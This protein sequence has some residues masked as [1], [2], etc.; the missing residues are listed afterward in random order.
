[1]K[2]R[3]WRDDGY[4][5]RSYAQPSTV[6]DHIGHSVYSV[7]AEGYSAVAPRPNSKDSYRL[8]PYA[9]LHLVDPQPIPKM[10]VAVDVEVDPQTEEVMMVGL[11]MT[12]MGLGEEFLFLMGIFSPH[13]TVEI[14]N[15]QWFDLLVGY[16]LYGYDMDYLVKYGL[17]GTWLETVKFRYGDRIEDLEVPFASYPIVDLYRVVQ[18]WDVENGG[19]LESFTLKDVGRFFGW[20]RY[21]TDDFL[22]AYRLGTVED[23]LL[24]DLWQTLGLALAHIPA[25][26]VKSR[27]LCFDIQRMTVLGTG[28]LIDTLLML[29]YWLFG[30]NIPKR[31]KGRE[32]YEGAYVYAQPTVRKGHIFTV[33]FTSLYPSIVEH[34]RLRPRHDFLGMFWEGVAFLKRLRVQ[35]KRQNTPLSQNLQASLKIV[36][37]SAY[38]YHGSRFAFSDIEVAKAITSTGRWKVQELVRL[39]D[40]FGE[41]VLVDT[42]GIVVDGDAVSPRD[43]QDWLNMRLHPYQVEVDKYDGVVVIAQKNYVLFR[44]DR[45][46]KVK[47]NSLRNRSDEKYI[48]DLLRN[49]I[50]HLYESGSIEYGDVVAEVA[51]RFKDLMKNPER[52]VK[53]QRVGKFMRMYR[54]E[55]VE[56]LADGERV[57]MVKYKDGWVRLNDPSELDPT[58][59]DWEYYLQKTFSAVGRLGGVFEQVANDHLKKKAMQRFSDDYGLGLAILKSRQRNR[60]QMSLV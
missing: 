34:E 2:L 16:N 39:A 3:R 12:P 47:G 14:L 4:E 45:I 60:E 32:D 11:G 33:D 19:V 52:L 41:V 25:L 22:E 6:Y 21:A 10:V 58:R 50:Y 35:Y 28:T 17:Q 54:S 40:S 9:V 30:L 24:D 26:S 53:T 57:S 51:K 15:E 23:Y 36:I 55:V 27:M 29:P 37:N 5:D 13:D 20:G 7:F 46:V 43:L 48:K 18:R 42:D 38:G 49:L 1:M 31:P 8:N 56:D 59:I 44:N